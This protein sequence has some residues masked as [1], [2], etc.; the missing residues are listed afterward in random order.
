MPDTVV[1]RVYVEDP[2]DWDLPDK[3]FSWL[4]GEEY[5]H[6]ELDPDTGNITMKYGTPNGSYPLK[7]QVRVERRRWLTRQAEGEARADGAPGGVLSAV[8]WKCVFDLAEC[9]VLFCADE[10]LPV[11]LSCT[12]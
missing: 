11:R 9:C 6:F 12:Y 2:D 1:G 4:E 3:T 7:F 5:R 10:L 8:S